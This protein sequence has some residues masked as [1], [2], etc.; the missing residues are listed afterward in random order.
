MP[1]WFFTCEVGA[2]DDPSESTCEAG[3]FG[4]AGR[5]L[6]QLC[7][8][9]AFHKRTRHGGFTEQPPWRVEVRP[10]PQ[11]PARLVGFAS[12]I[13]K[14]GD[15]DDSN[16]AAGGLGVT[17]KCSG[18]FV[19]AGSPHKRPERWMSRARQAPPAQQ[20]HHGYP[21]DPSTFCCFSPAKPA[22]PAILV[23]HPVALGGIRAA[24]KRTLDD[25]CMQSMHGHQGG[26][27]NHGKPTDPSMPGWSLLV[28]S[29]KPASLVSPLVK[30]A[31][32]VR[33]DSFCRIQ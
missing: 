29:P 31:G 7:V 21:T 26:C 17:R 15:P 9:G 5:F 19:I 13:G 25:G 24:W 3:E 4:A 28:K 1:G 20:C 10:S 22:K 2:A 6:Q 18:K 14:A 27:A 11:I 16:C 23:H 8:C 33:P 30:L 32:W 12:E